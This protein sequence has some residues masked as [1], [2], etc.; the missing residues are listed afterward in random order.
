MPASLICQRQISDYDATANHLG[1]I[2]LHESGQGTDA[3]WHVR[4]TLKIPGMDRLALPVFKW[5]IDVLLKA[6]I[7]TA[8]RR[9]T[10]RLSDP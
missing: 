5:F 1:T 6:N 2:T 3:V 7:A 9:A 8:E 10:Q 4:A